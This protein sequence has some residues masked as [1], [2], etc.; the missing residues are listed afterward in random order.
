MQLDFRGRRKSVVPRLL[1]RPQVSARL[2]PGG[3][4]LRASVSLKMADEEAG[5]AERME[6]SP[7]LPQTPQRL[8][9]VSP[10]GQVPFVPPAPPYRAQKD[11]G[12]HPVWR[13]WGG[14]VVWVDLEGIHQIKLVITHTPAGPVHGV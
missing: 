1:D 11:A 5:E 12:L 13:L 14:G 8:A 6:V 10:C 7:E 3:L 2:R 9:S 4:Q